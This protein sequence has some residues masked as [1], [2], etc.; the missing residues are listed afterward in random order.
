MIG[1]LSRIVACGIAGLGFLAPTSTGL[2]SSSHEA[3]SATF[4][5]V[6]TVRRIGLMPEAHCRT[7]WC[8]SIEPGE[9][10]D[11]LNCANLRL[12]PRKRCKQ[13]SGSMGCSTCH[14]YLLMP[15]KQRSKI[16]SRSP[17]A[18]RM[19][20]TPRASA[21]AR[22]SSAAPTTTPCATA[23]HSATSASGGART[24]I[25]ASTKTTTTSP[26]AR[27]PTPSISHASTNATTTRP[28]DAAATALP[29]SFPQPPVPSTLSSKATPAPMTDHENA[30]SD[31]TDEP[32]DSND[33]TSPRRTR[34]PRRST[35]PAPST[36]STPFPSIAGATIGNESPTA[37]T[38]ASVL[39]SGAI[40]GITVGGVAV[41]LGVVGLV[42]WR[43]KLAHDV[44]YREML[45]SDHVTGSGQYLAML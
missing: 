6:L 12:M 39:S 14:G 42:V 16:E 28:S 40:A 25:P 19:P 18:T 8:V 29:Q 2:P 24:S 44:A 30:T 43:K 33:M 37:P 17:A 32:Y 26:P 9:A 5:A 45:L 7:G 15:P 11:C 41:C 36:T 10:S 22:A 20:S 38:E 35:P 1:R 21:E 23:I 31:D 27:A 34:S 13:C 3:Y 4:Q